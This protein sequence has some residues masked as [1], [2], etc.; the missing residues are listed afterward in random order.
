MK[1][2]ENLLDNILLES[3]RL[4]QSI[5]SEFKSDLNTITKSKV[6]AWA[7]MKATIVSCVAKL[8]YP[9]WDTRY[10][11]VQIGGK[12]S[13]R[14]IDKKYVA[15]YLFKKG[16]Y[17]TATEYALTRSFEKAEPF[18]M[19][20]TGKITPNSCKQ[21]FLRI[22]EL[23]NT[24]LSSDNVIREILKYLL[25]DLKK[26]H[27][28]QVLLGS[29]PISIIIPNINIYS[30]GKFI[31]KV[32]TINQ[33]GWCVIPT[34]IVHTVM[35]NV[36]YNTDKKVK[37]L[38]EH[39]SPDNNSHAFGDVEVYKDNNPYIVIEIKTSRIDD[40]IIA[41]FAK[42]TYSVKQKFILTTDKIHPFLTSDDI[43]VKT[44]SNFITDQLRYYSIFCSVEENLK[45]ATLVSSMYKNIMSY[46]NLSI[47]VKKDVEN[48]F[49][50]FI[51]T[52]S[53]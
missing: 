41:T 20:Y 30:I 5:I 49:R 43:E 18:T 29:S 35:S 12:Y 28:S 24:N 6:K 19:N 46:N 42:K 44:V 36:F 38:R 14:S 7:P 31:Q 21:A 1:D 10:H 3:D 47:P 4:D 53:I 22:T 13:L 52:G 15:F 50:K 8:I 37:E 45:I 39:T 27:K 32:F 34:I 33:Y 17:P 11:Q 40:N 16:L 48:L 2:I 9:D 25:Y 26:Y 51:T 23:I